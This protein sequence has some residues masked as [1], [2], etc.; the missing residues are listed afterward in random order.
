MI[1]NSHMFGDIGIDSV[2]FYAPKYY[3][4]LKDLAFERN[5][6]PDKYKKGLMSIEMRLPAI[7]EDIISIGLKAGYNAL[8]KGNVSPKSIDAVFCGTETITYAVKSVSNIY[9]ELLGAPRNVLTQDIYN[10]CAGG[11]LA[12]LNAIALVEKEVIERALVISADISSYQMHSPSEPTQGSGAIALVI[13]KNPRIATFSKKFG[14]VSGNVND[15]W[16]PAN[17]VNANAF[18]QYSVEAYLNFQL[19][20][21]D[22]LINH[23]G[24]FHADYYTFHAPFAK[25][26]IKIM[27]Q[28]IQKRWVNHIN[29]LP[30]IRPQP[31]IKK[32]I[33]QKLNS[34]LHDITV[35]PEYIYLKLRER[36]YSSQTL[37]KISHQILENVKYK[38]LP[39][40]R[41]PSHFGN[42]YNAAVWAQILYILEN[43]GH[44][45]DTIYFGSY[46]SGAT[47]IS[48]LLRVKP[49]FKE[50]VGKPPLINDFITIK[51]RRSVSEYE[52]MKEGKF[53]ENIVLGKIVEHEE[54]NHRGFK[55]HFCD[56]G[57]IIPNIEGLNHCP[58]GHS[59]FHERFFPLFAIL[60]SE[61]MV[62]DDNNDLSYLSKGLVRIT[63]KV[64]QGNAL[65]YEIRRIDNN[66]VKNGEALGLL[67][68]APIYL[69]VEKI[70]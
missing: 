2:G 16:R 59:G 28:I 55:L 12:I 48:G 5:V 40:L 38:V 61:P 21:Y 34:F 20:A 62:L 58:K 63:G 8:V 37:E 42:M 56:E 17:D 10:A 60:D 46:G 14:K 67:N 57:C 23:L 32:S 36:G 68:W 31:T 11:T 66:S 9:A 49:G 3:L 18:G 69:P 65:E 27:Q 15:F 52:L 24:D 30:K 22:D 64:T 33:K 26:P 51:E 1:N 39:Q 7:D 4:K 45:H 70:Y 43:Y 19:T 47:C 35:L 6:D 13:S 41:V 44:V 50:I 54:N 29:T 25:L 53:M